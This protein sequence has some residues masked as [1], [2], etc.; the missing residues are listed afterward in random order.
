MTP[1]PPTCLCGA[2]PTC[3]KRAWRHRNR[4]KVKASQDAWGKTRDRSGDPKI[5]E[6]NRQY[7]LRRPWRTGEPH[8]IDARRLLRNA[9]RRGEVVKLPCVKC[10]VTRV[11]GHH[12]D[13][14]KPLDVIWLCSKHHADRHREIAAGE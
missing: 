1:S 8:K 6:Y 14:D 5:A 3:Y 13:Y 4:D 9:L 10:G 12:E 2:C 7:S 11:H